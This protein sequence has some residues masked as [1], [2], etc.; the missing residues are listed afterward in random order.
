M[1]SKLSD[2]ITLVA[3]IE[4]PNAS[5]IT[6]VTLRKP[7]AGELRGLKLMEVMRMDVASHIM[8]LPRITEPALMPDE[9]DQMDP[10][11]FMS[12]V[13]G[14]MGFFVAPDQLAAVMAAQP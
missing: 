2:P 3:P 14:V 7:L 12:L 10:A 11:D 5:P 9:L 4:R 13:A 8:L 6:T 1:T